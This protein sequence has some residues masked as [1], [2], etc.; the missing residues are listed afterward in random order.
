MKKTTIDKIKKYS[1]WYLS[2]GI[3]YLIGQFIPWQGSYF[4]GQIRA[5]LLTVFTWPLRLFADFMQ[6]TLI[7][8]K[9]PEYI[10]LLLGLGLYYWFIVKNKKKN[11]ILGV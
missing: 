6:G 10:G 1:F 5:I 11:K 3:G 9:L 8:S 2:G 7:Y 4:T